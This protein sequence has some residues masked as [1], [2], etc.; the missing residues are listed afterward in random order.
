MEKKYYN[1]GKANILNYI[2]HKD[3]KSSGEDLYFRNS[4]SN[5]KC[6]A[7][8]EKHPYESYTYCSNPN[9][10]NFNIAIKSKKISIL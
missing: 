9:K 3:L 5:D 4:Q 1:P 2:L 10:K 8:Q 6:N 7:Y